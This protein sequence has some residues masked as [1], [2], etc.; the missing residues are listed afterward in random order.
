[1]RLI[2]QIVR[3]TVIVLFCAIALAAFA[4]I[5]TGS[6]TV[7][8]TSGSMSPAIATGDAVVVTELDRVGEVSVGDVVV[9][10]PDDTGSMKIIHRVIEIDRDGLGKVSSL[11][12]MGDANQ[13]A[14]DP[15]SPEQVLSVAQFIMPGA[16]HLFELPAWVPLS[17]TLALIALE[18]LATFTISSATVRQQR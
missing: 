15:I 6:R 8:V 9:F 17:V 13:V 5:L 4:L 10:Q 11:V 7:I 2:A 14:D 3:P 18:R 1:M 16:G 12:T